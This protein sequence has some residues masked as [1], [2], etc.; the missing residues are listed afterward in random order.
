LAGGTE[1]AENQDAMT[2]I[3]QIQAPFS[4]FYH[5]NL[6][7][8]S[9]KMETGYR[10]REIALLA[11]YNFFTSNFQRSRYERVLSQEYINAHVMHHPL[12]RVLT[13][14]RQNGISEDITIGIFGSLVTR[15]KGQD[16]VLKVLSQQ[17]WRERNWRVLLFGE[18]PDE[19]MLREIAASFGIQ[20]QV[21]F[22]GFT[23]MSDALNEVDLVLIP[24]VNDSGPIVLFEAMLAAKP[25]VGTPMGAMPEFLINDRTGVIA[26]DLSDEAL[27]DAM[28]FAWINVSKWPIWGQNCQNLINSVYDFNPEETL[29]SKLV[30]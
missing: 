14:E 4:V 25:I 9:I 15:W 23:D 17:K 22:C 19:K 18:G 5:S 3:R 7:E 8:E 1:I 20:N 26:R 6:R 27:D 2:F 12:K 29:L 10:L 13:C 28:E 24:S 11:K 16:K 30:S 21:H